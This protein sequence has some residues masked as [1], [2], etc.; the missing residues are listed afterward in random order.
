MGMHTKQRCFS[1]LHAEANQDR[2][3]GVSIGS[4]WMLADTSASKHYPY[5]VN[6]TESYTIP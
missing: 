4:M 2:A 5:E 1:P 6:K 3:T